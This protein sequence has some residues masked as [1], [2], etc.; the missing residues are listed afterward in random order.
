MPRVLLPCLL[1]FTGW[2][3]SGCGADEPPI[4]IIRYAHVTAGQPVAWQ[5]ALAEGA[6][7]VQRSAGAG[8]QAWAVNVARP[9][10]AAEVAGLRQALRLAPPRVERREDATGDLAHGEHWVFIQLRPDGPRL[11]TA[12]RARVPASLLEPAQRA[13]GPPLPLAAGAGPGWIL[14]L[15]LDERGQA[16]AARLGL[17]QELPPSAVLPE[18]LQRAV[19][20]PGRMIASAPLTAPVR[21]DAVAPIAEI[22]WGGREFRLR[23]FSPPAPHTPAP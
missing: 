18:S 16:D 21:L 7:V 6:G 12:E 11:W 5:A 20:T 10:A 14:A 4:Y 23:F 19:K 8:A 17:L 13:L 9:D 1:F 22:R 3:T 15:P 2:C